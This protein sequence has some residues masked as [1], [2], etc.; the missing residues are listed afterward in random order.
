MKCSKNGQKFAM[1]KNTS[2]ILFKTCWT[3]CKK[4]HFS[5]WSRLRYT[6]FWMTRYVNVTAIHVL[7]SIGLFQSVGYCLL[8]NTHCILLISVLKGKIKMRKKRFETTGGTSSTPGAGGRRQTSKSKPW[9]WQLKYHSNDLVRH[10][11][12]LIAQEDLIGLKIE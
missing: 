11:C 2:N 4:P 8:H 1:S 10:L 5:T 9:Q 7:T 3:L 12:W 6:F